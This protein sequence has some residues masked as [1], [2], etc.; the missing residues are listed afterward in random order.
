MVAGSS[1]HERLCEL[2]EKLTECKDDSQQRGWALHEDERII[3]DN[4]DEMLS[5]LV[6]YGYTFNTFL[7]SNI[8]LHF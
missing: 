2:F 7:S 6:K 4:L 5:I 8:V 3:T 1:D